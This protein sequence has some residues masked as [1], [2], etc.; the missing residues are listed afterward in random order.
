MKATTTISGLTVGTTY[1]FRV[2]VQTRK[3]MTDWC[4]PVS[5]VVR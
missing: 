5:L 2:R 4:A 3:G 1:W